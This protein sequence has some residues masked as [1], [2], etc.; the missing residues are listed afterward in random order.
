MTDPGRRAPTGAP[1]ASTPVFVATF[2]FILLIIVAL[3]FVDTALA[4]VD[5][6][7]SRAHAANLYRDGQ[8][9]LARGDAHEASD[10]F[11]SAVASNRGEPRYALALA[12]AMLADGRTDDARR[13]LDDVLERIPADGAANLTMARVLVTDGRV[14]DAKSY[15]HRAIYGRWGSDSAARRTQARLELVDLLAKR[16]ESAEMLA[17]LLPLDASATDTAMR[18]RIGLLFIEAGAPERGAA[19]L[20]TL[21]AAAAAPR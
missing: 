2:G 6:R 15:F 5:E 19:L 12:Q 9:L 8:D 13:I 3:L 17:E 1:T 16:R 20:R 11:A 14:D 21:P 7:E 18:R 4:R 10:R